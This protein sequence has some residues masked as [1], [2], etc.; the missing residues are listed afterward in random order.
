MKK[1]SIIIPCYNEERTILET[2][3][4]VERADLGVEKEIIIVD[5]GSSDRTQE[6]LRAVRGA[7]RVIHKERNEG[8]GAAVRAGAAS[9]TGE[10]I[11]IQDADAEYDPRDLRRLVQV[12]QKTN[13]RVVYGS[14]RL[15]A[16]RNPKAGA[17]YYAGG[18][19]LSWLANALYGL[20]ITDEPTCYKL[21]ARDLLPALDLRCAG[22]EFCPELTAKVARLGESISEVPISYYPRSRSEGK[23][24]K[25]RDGF[26]AIGTL[27]RYRFW[28][29][30][31]GRRLLIITQALDADDPILGFFHGWVAAFA[32]RA[33]A[34]TV[35]A[36]RVGKH[37]LPP[38]VRVISC[39]PAAKIV[40]YVRL[41]RY[42][43]REAPR[44]TAV[45]THMVPEFAL[46]AGPF[47]RFFK[48]RF[49]MFYAHRRIS[50]RL[51]LA[52]RF[53][54]VM[55]TSSP[56]GFR[57]VSRKVRVIGQ[58][59]DTDL[60][61]PRTAPLPPPYRLLTVGRISPAKRVDVIIDA[62]AVIRSHAR[63]HDA[64][65]T[66]VGDAYLSSD[67]AYADAMRSK[68]RALGIADAVFWRGAVP[69][70][71]LPELYRNHHLF[72][73][74]SETGSMD[75]TVLE[76]LAAGCVVYSS[77]EAYAALLPD[78]F[79]F[80]RGDAVALAARVVAEGALA[81]APAE[82]RERVCGEHGLSRFI[83]VIM[84]SLFP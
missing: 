73:H 34:V 80:P 64:T 81:A 59:I 33:D 19:L 84:G 58:G 53:V 1:L 39:G 20:R 48:R 2:I 72:L 32:L 26:I 57:V 51:W 40:R 30:A 5:D 78:R 28:R 38:H 11:V 21:F 68:T 37:D 66:I 16:S 36:H 56:E 60:F 10:Y 62:F 6:A 70:A 43:A 55:F 44:H 17:T 8:K 24:I 67:R 15:G 45:F 18:V 25:W 77:S 61:S 46:L 27:L 83:D 79:R 29:P 35:I 13:A 12:V 7:H 3:R 31:N 41:I 52:L 65:L 82:P 63:W 42:I 71:A 76:A 50:L 54:D 47:T 9:A 23:K 22:F 69:Y 4:R 49:A 74:A 14:R 75:K